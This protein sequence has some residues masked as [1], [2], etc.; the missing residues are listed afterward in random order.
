VNVLERLV[1]YL[2]WTGDGRSALDTARRAADL[3]EEQQ[4]DN[5]TKFNV[6]ATFAS[7][8]LVS[9]AHDEALKKAIH[10]LE[11]S[12]SIIGSPELAEVRANLL[13][14]AGVAKSLGGDT[15]AGLALLDEAL[16]LA[17]QTP[18]G[19]AELRALNNK[20]F[21]L[22]G[23]G[24][25]EEAASG[26]L[27]G[28]LLARERH[29]DRSANALLLANLVGCLETLGRWGEAMHHVDDGLATGAAPEVRASL[30]ANAAHIF[31]FRGE[32]DRARKAATDAAHEIAGLTALGMHAQIAVAAADVELV[33]G[34][35]SGAL[36]IAIQA[37]SGQVASDDEVDIL[38]LTVLGLMAFRAARHL[39]PK[40]SA[41]NLQTF[42]TDQVV[43]MEG[44]ADSQ[45]HDRLRSAWAATSRAAAHA[46]D[47]LSAAAEWQAAASLWESLNVPVWRIR[48]LIESAEADA[49]HNRL[50]ATRRL[51]E[52]AE[53]ALKLDAPVLVKDVQALARRANL[54]LAGPPAPKQPPL[55]ANLTPREHEVLIMVS[56]GATNR[57]I[58]RALF[59]SERTAGVHVSN[60]LRK[61]G[62]KNRGE[63]AA[64]GYR[65]NLTI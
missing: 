63:A 57:M 21:V 10:V 18:G 6:L 31:A 13:I 9:G 55:P 56:N 42:L 12:K 20:S 28:I 15:G 35:A 54:Q 8:L 27:E 64:I 48:C 4:T 34:S 59:I 16:L 1:H 22:Q 58:G 52:A 40:D 62:A 61:L 2:R 43:A 49:H 37:L 33:A 53:A 47:G 29:L 36:D 46:A 30:L 39:L 41:Q 14:T 23:E 24:R 5:P 65:L 7:V 26:A 11:T 50:R 3:V 45:P 32:T 19:E 17:R 51:S 44:N 38:N 60:V 25:Y